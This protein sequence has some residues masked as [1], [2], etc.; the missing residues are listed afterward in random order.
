MELRTVSLG[1]LRPDVLMT[2]RFDTISYVLITVPSKLQL[3]DKGSMRSSA[4]LDWMEGT[5]TIAARQP[6]CLLS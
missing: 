3:D 1:L 5:G 2:M 4:A 6:V